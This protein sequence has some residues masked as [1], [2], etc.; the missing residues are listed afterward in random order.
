MDKCAPD[1]KIMHV[2]LMY[3]PHIPTKVYFVEVFKMYFSLISVQHISSMSTKI[4]FSTD[5]EVIKRDETVD[6]S[7][8][9]DVKD[10]FEIHRCMDFVNNN[11][12]K[13]VVLQF[14]DELMNY[15]KHV[16]E[17]ISKG[18]SANCFILGDTSYGSCCVDEVA[19]S[20]VN[21]DAIIHFGQ[22]CMSF[23]EKIPVLYIFGKLSLDKENLF[24]KMEE[25]FSDKDSKIWFFYDVCFYH[26][27]KQIF[28]ELKSIYSNLV[29]SELNDLDVTNKDNYNQCCFGRSS[30]LK[31][32]LSD[33]NIFFVGGETLTLRNLIL[34]YNKNKVFS[35]NPS[36]KK[37]RVE[38]MNV[39]K[40][41]M[42]RF[43]LIEKAKDAQ[44]VGIIM[45]TLGVA[46]Y[47]EMVSR[48]KE[49]LKHAGK[50]FYTFIIGKINVAK[51]ANF[52]EIDIFVLVAC[53]ENSLIESKEFYKPIVTP[54]EMEIACLSNRE[55]TGNYVTEFKEILPGG[56]TYVDID[57][58]NN[59]NEPEYSLITGQLRSNK[60]C[61]EEKNSDSSSDLILSNK[62]NQVLR[63]AA[64]EYLSSRTWQGLEIDHQNSEVKK[65][66]DGRSGIA[67]SYENEC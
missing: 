47:K 9:D 2:D 18:T 46:K 24:E 23:T 3:I 5:N 38:N 6:Q 61:L 57:N 56:S 26:H 42:R 7:I 45:G 19:A 59:E 58:G 37:I 66:E 55:W 60:K 41:L 15:S 21:G 36:T 10:Y 12:F 40:S 17:M 48:L 30:S 13:N 20:H 28:E 25:T 11:N 32:N 65:A 35:Y 63:Y 39:N 16:F 31:F 22:S 14:P 51:M 67:M 62:E 34:K 33:Y 29:V 27:I 52:M 49:V 4:N 43:F 44:I 8:I 53:P 50:K 54:Y 64:S 1:P